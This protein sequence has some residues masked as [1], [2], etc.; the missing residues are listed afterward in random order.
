ET[1]R[2]VGRV[3]NR[4]PLAVL[5]TIK[6]HDAEN[7]SQA[8]LAGAAP[9]IGEAEK[10][11]IAK[12]ARHGASVAEL[13]ARMELPRWAI[14]RAIVDERVRRLLK[15]RTRFYDDSLYHDEDA[16]GAIAEIVA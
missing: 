15:R 8:I 10:I 2:R 13:S 7:I 11:A 12:A 5:H 16:A 6:K 3:L 4:S 14:Y 1:T 9:E